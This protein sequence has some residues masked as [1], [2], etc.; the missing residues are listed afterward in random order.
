[1]RNSNRNVYNRSEII[2]IRLVA[3][4]LPYLQKNSKAPLS[5]VFADDLKTAVRYGANLLDE[6]GIDWPR[7]VVSNGFDMANMKTSLLGRCF[8]RDRN[9]GTNNLGIDL[10]DLP[11][12]AFYT[13]NHF[14][15][16]V[17]NIL[18]KAAALSIISYN[19]R[20]LRR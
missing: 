2:E 15:Y 7:Q 17:L 3:I 1:M 4:D 8:P 18:W 12:Y 10:T 20:F 13:K 6:F 9:Y 19:Q 14:H 16:P 11:R 5:K